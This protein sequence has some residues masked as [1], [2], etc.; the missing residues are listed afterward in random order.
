MG[1]EGK[2]KRIPRPNQ[3]E[4]TLEPLLDRQTQNIL[5]LHHKAITASKDK[6]TTT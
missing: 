2:K 4:D 6:V 5:F 3:M 1:V